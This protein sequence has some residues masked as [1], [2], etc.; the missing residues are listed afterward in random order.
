M[1]ETKK[2]EP[3]NKPA[4]PTGLAVMK[5]AALPAKKAPRKPTAIRKAEPQ[6]IWQAFD[7][8]FERFRNDFQDILLPFSDVIVPMPETRVPAIDLEDH[9]KEYVLK[10]EMPGFK[11][12]DVEINVQDDAVEISAVTGW[13]YDAKEQ[14]YICKERA[15]KSFYRYVD[16]PEEIKVDDVNAD[17]SNGVL[18]IKLPKKTPKAK[19][20]VQVKSK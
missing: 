12:E 8:T 17:L 4:K 14:T 15:C 3:V 6:D 9:E 7:E 16:L 5:K 19:R 1:S 10:A 18:E 13:K 11:K 20:K 2:Q